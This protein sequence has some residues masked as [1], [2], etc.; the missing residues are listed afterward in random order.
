MFASMERRRSAAWAQHSNNNNNNLN[1]QQCYRNLITA[2]DE[3]PVTAAT[4]AQRPTFHCGL[5]ASRFRRIIFAP[6]A[7]RFCPPQAVSCLGYGPKVPQVL[8]WTSSECCSS[9]Q[10]GQILRL[11]TSPSTSSSTT[12]SS[13]I[14]FASTMK[15]NN[16]Y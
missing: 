14:V 8:S 16:N 4:E 1:L 6:P 5:K 12:T 13:T 2:F 11:L 15:M 7:P 3:S 10:L 9:W